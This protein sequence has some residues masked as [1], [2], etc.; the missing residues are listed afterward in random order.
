MKML[1][2]SEIVKKSAT[3][4]KQGLWSSNWHTETWFL[5]IEKLCETIEFEFLTGFQCNFG[6]MGRIKIFDAANLLHLACGNIDVTANTPLID[7]FL[8]IKKS[9]LLIPLLKKYSCGTHPVGLV[10]ERLPLAQGMI[11][12]SRDQV[13]HWAPSMELLLPLPVSLSVSLC[14]SHK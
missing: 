3:G 7:V 12:Q 14:V 11:P 4:K 1:R 5:Y 9:S 6:Q 2:N 10:V 13:P 8:I